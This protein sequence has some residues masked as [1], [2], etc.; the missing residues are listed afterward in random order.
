M[1][2]LTK[3]LVPLASDG[4]GAQLPPIDR[5]PFKNS[6]DSEAGQQEIVRS[7]RDGPASPPGPHSPAAPQPPRDAA[8]DDM[9]AQWLQEG[10]LYVHA[11]SG[12]YRNRRWRWREQTEEEQTWNR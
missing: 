4:G 5:R 11:P 9:I 7:W 6:P 10:W 3:P 8:I 2:Q 1:F 12:E